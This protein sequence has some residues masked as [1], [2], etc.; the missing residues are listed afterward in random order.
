MHHSCRYNFPYLL[1]R[2]SWVQFQCTVSGGIQRL[3][4]TRSSSCL[5][6]RWVFSVFTVCSQCVML[7]Y[8][9]FTVCYVV[10]CCVE[11]WACLAVKC[12]SNLYV[13]VISIVCS[14]LC[15]RWLDRIL[16]NECVLSTVASKTL[17]LQ[18]GHSG[19]AHT[20][21]LSLIS[22]R[23]RLPIGILASSSFHCEKT[24]QNRTEQN[25]TEQNKSTTTMSGARK[26]QSK[27]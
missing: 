21:T 10:L 17:S 18:I 15:A 26:L 25:R 11:F 23:H 12:S 6:I 8:V 5:V 24:E 20:H 1:T 7:C 3:S 13:T 22:E 19:T 14:R 16:E 2:K 27:C 9:V 4:S